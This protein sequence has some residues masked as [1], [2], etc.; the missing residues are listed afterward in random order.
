MFIEKL[1]LRT[2]VKPSSMM[3]EIRQFGAL[4]LDGGHKSVW[5]SIY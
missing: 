5:I 2:F 1:K 4:E 3:M